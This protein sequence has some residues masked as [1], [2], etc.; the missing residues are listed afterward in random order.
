ME[1]GNQ[2]LKVQR[3]SVGLQQA[4]GLEMGVNAMSMLAGTTSPELEQGRVLQLLNM[5]TAEELMDNEEY[6]GELQLISLL[7]TTAK[8]C[9]LTEICQD[10]KEECEK[11]G[12]V[13]ELKIPRPSGGRQVPGV[14]K[15]FVKYDVPESAQTALKSLAGRKFADR[16]VVVTFFGE[17]RQQQSPV[18][19]LK[20]LTN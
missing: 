11:Y 18:S 4:S 3:A 13:V 17:V 2:H 5:V 20:M 14:G 9:V 6:E 8:L 16:T 10:V 7:A 15:I 19:K 1:L 12:Q